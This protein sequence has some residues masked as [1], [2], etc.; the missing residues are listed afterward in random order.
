M[1]PAHGSQKLI[2]PIQN[3]ATVMKQSNQETLQSGEFE[4]G[5][6]EEGMKE[7]GEGAL[8]KSAMEPRVK[9]LHNK[10]MENQV[11]VKLLRGRSQDRRSKSK[12]DYS[13]PYE[14]KYSPNESM[15]NA[16]DFSKQLGRYNNI[17]IYYSTGNITI[18]FLMF[19][20]IDSSLLENYLL[21]LQNAKSKNL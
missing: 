2:S 6:E 14:A 9:Y 3:Y 15:I 1:S 12:F 5:E 16:V 4:E 20:K 10:S 8:N 18:H 13:L 11:S 7:F 19:M 21:F 17:Y